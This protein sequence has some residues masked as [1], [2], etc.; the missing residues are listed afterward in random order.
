M[1]KNI[2]L[3]CAL[4]LMSVA[5]YAAYPE[6]DIKV[7]IPFSPGGGFDSYVRAVIPVLKKHL[8]GNVNILPINS[9]G[10]GG[11][12]GALETFRAKPDGY[13]IG[14]FN[15]PG[16]LI[17]QLTEEKTRFDLAQLTWLATFGTDPYAYVVNKDSTLKS[18][19]D[20]RA[21]KQPVMY[22]AT[23]PSSTSYVATV[24]MNEMLGIPYEMVTGYTGSSE[25]TMG[26][27]RGDVAAALVS[28]STARPFIK[29]GDVRALAMIGVKSSDP[30]IADAESMGKPEIGRLNVV[31][32]LAAPPGLPAEIKSTLEKAILAAMADPEFTQWLQQTGN[33][34]DPA[35]AAATAAAVRDLMAF[36]KQYL[37]ILKK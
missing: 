10:A 9:G 27:M 31:R 28:M 21:Q 26:V 23:G 29:S 7:I 12:Q 5:A 30:A 2:L 19:A 24:L 36:Y 16:V 34:A 4:L 25:Y 13:T 1:Y 14:V 15:M 8:G 32:M 6:R 37:H 3:S 35:G 20:V 11:R 33:D 18:F 22:G 17:A